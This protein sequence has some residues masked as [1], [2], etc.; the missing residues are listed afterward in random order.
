MSHAE[1]DVAGERDGLALDD[2]AA[3]A[4]FV[5]PIAEQSPQQASIFADGEFMLARSARIG[6]FGDAGTVGATVDA[7]CVEGD[8]VDL[9]LGIENVREKEFR[10]HNAH[11][12]AEI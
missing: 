1:G 12:D 9:V 2:Y 10:L 6:Y 11:E 7:L 4:F 3:A 8:E 5:E